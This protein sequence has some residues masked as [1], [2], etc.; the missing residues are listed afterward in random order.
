MSCSCMTD[1]IPLSLW[2]FKSSDFKVPLRGSLFCGSSLNVRRTVLFVAFPFFS[3]NDFSHV[4]CYFVLQDLPQSVLPFA[5]IP[6][7]PWVLEMSLLGS[8][9]VSL[10]DPMDFTSSKFL[11]AWFFAFAYKCNLRSLLEHV[12]WARFTIWVRRV[13]FLK[14]VQSPYSP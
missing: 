4:V 3:H 10:R 13:I 14:I 6:R 2:I 1:S 7:L 8:L 9:H 5:R 12:T 11:F